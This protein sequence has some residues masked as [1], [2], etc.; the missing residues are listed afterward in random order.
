MEK[1]PSL[2][3]IL[4]VLYTKLK[5]EKIFFLIFTI[6]VVLTSIFYKPNNYLNTQLSTEKNYNLQQQKQASQKRNYKSSI[7]DLNTAS[8]E[9]LQTLPGIGPSKAK[10]IVEYREKSN[11]SKPEDIMNVSGIG[12]KTFEKIKD[13]ITVSSP[14][15]K[16]DDK[17]KENTA[18]DPKVEIIQQTDQILPVQSRIEAHN[19]NQAQSNENNVVESAKININTSS[20]EELQQLPG[21]GPTKAQAIVDYR[22]K[23]GGFKTIE[24]IKN[25]KG[26]GEKTFEKLKDLITTK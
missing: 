22:I 5:N 13:R 2:F 21:I 26:I 3:D 14:G 23:N 1:V 17:E 19:Q 9:E 6:L 8:I 11:F 10:A 18:V 25:V 7:V 24:E 12:Q 15:E 16:K 20:I 4:K